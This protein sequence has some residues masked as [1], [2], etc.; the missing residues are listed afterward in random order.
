[1]TGGRETSKITKVRPQ[2][3]IFVTLLAYWV[4]K[5]R[6]TLICQATALPAGK[7]VLHETL[8]HRPHAAD[9]FPSNQTPKESSSLTCNGSSFIRFV[10]GLLN[11]NPLTS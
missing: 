10:A 6:N 8:D 1:M 5:D 7:K 9:R 2:S 11:D 4:E 3:E